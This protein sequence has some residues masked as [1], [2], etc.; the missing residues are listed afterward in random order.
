V[1]LPRGEI[2]SATR[3]RTYL[4]CP[5]GYFLR[6][7][8]G[9]PERPPAPREDLEGDSA[10]LPADL[11]GRL[12]HAVMERI[13]TGPVNQEDLSALCAHAFDL[14][15]DAAHVNREE[16]IGH[17]S[18]LVGGVTRCQ[19]W[20]EILS[21][22]DT[23]TEFTLSIPLDTEFLTGTID[24]TYVDSAGRRVVLDYKTDVV[25][26]NTIAEAAQRHRPQLA[27]YA[28]LAQS[29]FGV[30]A[31]RTILLFARAPDKPVER[32]YTAADLGTFQGEVR[33][34]FRRIREGDFPAS[35]RT[36]S[37]CPLGRSRCEEAMKGIRI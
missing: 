16:V 37:A 10:D 2:Y 27:V 14:E 21:G 20:K 12:F 24:R 25:E 6:Y 11:I 28:L 31:V 17:V 34:V 4:E 22:T 29:Y 9:F 32:V 5:A 15:G 33:Q 1:S 18:S 26:E 35:P 8:L 23:R 3:L 30:D 19:L 7:V 36:C 13:G